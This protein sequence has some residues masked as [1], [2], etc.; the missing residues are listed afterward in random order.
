[1][2]LFS[3]LKKK[4]IP[5]NENSVAFRREMAQR[6]SGKIVKYVSERKDNV[7]SLLGHEGSISL[8]DGQIIVLSSGNIVMRC[9]ADKMKA[10]ELLSLDGVIITAP[11]LE[12]N[13]EEH[14]IV[15]Y[16]KYFR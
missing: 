7:E 14:T 1:M 11:D 8:R 5:K 6:I 4:M 9:S 16:Y 2:G 10:S 3:R 12:R 15:A 13:G